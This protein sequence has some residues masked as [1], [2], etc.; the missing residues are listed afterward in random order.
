MLEVGLDGYVLS[1]Q[2]GETLTPDTDLYEV[3]DQGEKLYATPENIEVGEGD[4]SP[5]FYDNKWFDRIIG[6]KKPDN[7]IYLPQ[8][9]DQNNKKV[10]VL[11]TRPFHQLFK[12]PGKKVHLLNTRTHVVK[13]AQVTGINMERPYWKQSGWVRGWRG[14]HKGFY[15]TKYGS[16]RGEIDETYLGSHAFYIFSPPDVLKQSYHWA[17]FSRKGLD[18]YSIHFSKNPK[19][20]SAG[21]LSVERLIAEAYQN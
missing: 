13:K 9:L 7:V 1:R 10:A 2:S 16:W 14:K 5:P 12:H 11:G 6:K 18:K 3:T 20:M 15:N 8:Q 4:L 19:D 21:I 17:C